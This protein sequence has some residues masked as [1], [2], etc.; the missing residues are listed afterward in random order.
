M[1]AVWSVPPK[2]GAHPEF[3]TIWK[4][5]NLVLIF[6]EIRISLFSFGLWFISMKFS[7]LS[8]LLFLNMVHNVGKWWILVWGIIKYFISPSDPPLPTSFVKKV[9]KYWW[10]PSPGHPKMHLFGNSKLGRPVFWT[11]FQIIFFGLISCA[12]G[13]Y[14]HKTKNIFV[15]KVFNTP[16]QAVKIYNPLPERVKFHVLNMGFM[17]V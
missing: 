16:P 7:R 9:G 8:H 2:F 11:F 4:L 13:V 5:P 10:P 1:Y 12:M 6:G 14:K 3:G 15:K 17:G